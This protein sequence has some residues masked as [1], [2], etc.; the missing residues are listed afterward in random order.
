MVLILN[1]LNPF[2]VLTNTIYFC[3]IYKLLIKVQNQH[4][5]KV[6]TFRELY[7]LLPLPF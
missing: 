1:C 4:I 6:E 5:L 2:F 7:F 3:R